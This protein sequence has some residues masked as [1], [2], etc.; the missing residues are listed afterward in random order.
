MTGARSEAEKKYYRNKITE[1]TNFM[2]MDTD[3]V[4]GQVVVRQM[5]NIHTHK[6]EPERFYHLLK[7]NNSICEVF[8][9]ESKFPV[10][11]LKRDNYLPP[12]PKHKR[13]TNYVTSAKGYKCS[14]VE[15]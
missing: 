10:I 11:Q 13:V 15:G 3:N 6:K 7:D 14:K 2:D 8:I 9:C 1:V 12:M 5:K 4:T